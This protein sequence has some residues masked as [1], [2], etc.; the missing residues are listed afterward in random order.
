MGDPIDQRE[1]FEN[2]M[3]LLR[4]MHRWRMAF[5]GLVILLA[6]V[7]GGAALTLTVVGR[8]ERR[9]LPPPEEVVMQMLDQIGPRLGLSAEQRKEISPILRKHVTKLHEIWDAGRAQIAQELG[10]MNDEVSKTLT[11][12][13]QHAWQHLLQE[14]PGQFRRGLGPRRLGPGPGPE[15]RPSFRRGGPG[16]RER[17]PEGPAAPEETPLPQE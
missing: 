12:D 7:L 14:L 5:F 4:R 10:A 2:P 11:Q 1:N 6:G 8:T 16:G 9:E 17:F 15:G 3:L 13:Q